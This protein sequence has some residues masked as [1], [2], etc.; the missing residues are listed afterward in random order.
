M[1]LEILSPEKRIFTGEVSLIKVP[2]TNGSFEILDRHA[3]IISTLAAGKIKIV[4]PEKKVLYFEVT[5]GVVEVHKNEVS[6]LVQSE[7]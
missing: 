2:G 5:G 1:K 3:A 6:I 7:L 4:T